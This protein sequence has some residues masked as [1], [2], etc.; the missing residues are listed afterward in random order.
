MGGVVHRDLKPD[1]IMITKDDNLKIIDF[2]FA[3]G[4]SYKDD[5]D[6]SFKMKEKTTAGN[7]VYDAPELLYERKFSW[8]SDLWSF[9]G[10]IF[11]MLT[12][13]RLFD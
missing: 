5:F 6:P 4:V 8:G 12:G 2:G 1:N 9:A 7:K 13:K 3:R 11:F 10:I